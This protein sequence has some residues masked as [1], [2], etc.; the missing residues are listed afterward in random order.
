MRKW[1]SVEDEHDAMMHAR[2]IAQ[3][4]GDQDVS[5]SLTKDQL[6]T[7]AIRA[8]NIARWARKAEKE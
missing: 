7:I 5:I 3:T 4:L 2:F 1:S 8:E 6:R